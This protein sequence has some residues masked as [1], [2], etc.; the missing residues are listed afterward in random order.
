MGKMKKN[1]RKRELKKILALINILRGNNKNTR[2]DQKI[3][4]KIVWN[5][6]ISIVITITALSILLYIGFQSILM[7]RT[8]TTEKDKLIQIS[9]SLDYMIELARSLAIEC[10]SD[11]QLSKLLFFPNSTPI[12]DYLGLDHLRRFHHSMPHLHSIYLY[13]SLRKLYFISTS[14]EIPMIQPLGNFFDREIVK[15][16]KNEKLYNTFFPYPRFINE[17]VTLENRRKFPV[18]SFIV[19][20]SQERPSSSGSSIIINLSEKW[21][22]EMLNHLESKNPYTKNTFI[23]NKEGTTVIESG[24]GP[25]LTNLSEKPFVKKILS[26][27]RGEGFFET[28]INGKK[29]LVVFYTPPQYIWSFVKLIP[30]KQIVGKTLKLRNYTIIFAIFLLI[31]GIVVIMVLTKNIYSPINQ[32]I[33]RLSDLEKKLKD[34]SHIMKQNALKR[35]ILDSELFN[36]EHRLLLKEN[37]QLQIDTNSRLSMVLFLIDRYANFC[38]RYTY[39]ERG[40]LKYKMQTIFKEIL[41]KNDIKCESVD[42][43]EN[44][45]VLLTS[46][47]IVHS[48]HTNLIREVQERIANELGISLTAI[49]SSEC[50]D[51]SKL[52][53]LYEECGEASSYRLIYG[54]KSIINTEDTKN[55]KSEG[56]VYPHQ[57]DEKLYRALLLGKYNEIRENFEAI[58]NLSLAYSAKVV[59]NTMTRI[60]YT[61]NRAVKTVRENSGIVIK[62]DFF[63]FL[64]EIDKRETI[65]E[66]KKLFYTL[67]ERFLLVRKEKHIS[68]HDEIINSIVE[69]INTHFDDPNLGV[70]MIADYI[71]LTPAYLGFLFKT[72]IG[73]SFP[74]YINAIRIQHACELL[75]KTRDPINEIIHKTGFTN[76][77]HFYKVFKKFHGITPAEYR[78]RRRLHEV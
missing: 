4:I 50:S 21:M 63:S 35:L 13:N 77:S 67:V 25:M 60:A 5:V 53:T 68:K 75:V 16:Q 2:K 69:F 78:H 10:Y 37:Y 44:E 71:G 45:I 39:E 62:Y 18:Y 58:I 7:N 61:I 9:Y 42:M 47:P 28:K 12:E 14:S 29:Y 48:Y 19:D 72:Y 26:S 43:G 55:R 73:K 6:I 52:K 59:R 70:V 3:V 76:L 66:Y 65:E 34:N 74:D 30:F 17:P 38:S 40:L 56:W 32:M 41:S 23:I 22:R 15:L 24:F 49:L 31:M 64:T 27:G 33:I 46:P 8:Y 11:L 36:Y 54:Y 57:L 51:T 20:L 1:S